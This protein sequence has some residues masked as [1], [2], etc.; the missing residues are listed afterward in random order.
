M[1]FL[2]AFWQALFEC[3][4]LRLSLKFVSHWLIG[5]SAVYNFSL[6]W[7]ITI[8]QIREKAGLLLGLGFSN[9]IQRKL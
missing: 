3:C 1:S 4:R 5:N 6:I 8:Y 7:R 9:P 2:N